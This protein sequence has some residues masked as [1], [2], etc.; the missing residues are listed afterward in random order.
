[1][2]INRIKYLLMILLLGSLLPVSADSRPKSGVSDANLELRESSCNF[3]EVA[4]RGGDLEYELC[5][6]NT[7]TTPLVL[8]RVVTSCSCLKA[9]FQR[10]PVAPNEEGV[11]RIVYE[12]QKSEPGVFNKVIQIYS[13]ARNGRVIFTVQGTAIESPRIKIKEDKVVIKH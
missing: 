5:F 10:R 3:G 4:R 13:N 6:K 2:K 7:G 11:I 12:P 1:M 9:H 8:T